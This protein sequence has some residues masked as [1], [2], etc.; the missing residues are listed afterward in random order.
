MNEEIKDGLSL[1][2]DQIYDVGEMVAALAEEEAYKIED[3]KDC[4]AAIVKVVARYNE[5]LAA[6][7]DNERLGVERKYER[8]LMD[9]RRR[10]EFLPALRVEKP[11]T[12]ETQGVGV[13]NSPAP[14]QIASR[15]RLNLGGL[16][17]G[18]D[19][20]SWCG[21]CDSLRQHAIVAMIGD[22]VKQVVCGNCGGRHGHRTTPARSKKK[23][24]TSLPSSV[25]RRGGPSPKGS[26]A[27]VARMALQKELTEATDVRP[28]ALKARFKAGDIIEHDKY[29]RGKVENVL[30]DSILVRFRTGLRPLNMF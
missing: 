12:P 13:I 7:A 23:E 11:V 21:P 26:R 15:D 16:R 4:H 20:E 14:R 24:G 18:A 30:R 25:G 29:G 3:V 2:A 9:L 17:V 5:L 6:V 28:F 27:E 8:K 1:L 10:A 22:K 19:I